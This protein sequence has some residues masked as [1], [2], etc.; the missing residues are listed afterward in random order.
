MPDLPR[1]IRLAA[2]DYFMHGQDRR[3]RQ[4]GLPGNVC[5]AVVKLGAGFDVERLRRRIAE[6]PI[7]DWLAR[8][9]ISRTLPMV[10]PPLWRIAEK[11]EPIFFEHQNQ[12]GVADQPWNLPPA[13]AARELHAVR[14]PGL[15]FDVMRHADGTSHLFLS[16]NH[17]HLDA[18]G[19]DL[20]LNHLNADE[21]ANAPA[22]APNFINPKQL[23]SGLAG[24][25]PNVKQARGS[26]KWL[27]E[28]GAEPLFSLL[29]PGPR[30]RARAGII[31]ACFISP[32]RKRR[33]LT[34]AAS[35]STAVSAAAIFISRRRSA[36]CT[37]S[38][39]SAA[40][41]TAPT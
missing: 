10:F 19:L 38:P 4:V 22:K 13:V 12:N 2:G 8:A 37:T 17:T 41:K 36:R 26:K 11:P 14:G 3:M 23:G 27:D 40:T 16:W 25:W 20:L 1:Q 15:A 24:W 21:T 6:S 7:M 9:K 35:N 39:P 29:P 33:A 18:R 31:T 32:K 30:P 28:S 5:C 34:R